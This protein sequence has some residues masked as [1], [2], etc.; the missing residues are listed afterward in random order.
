M[1]I[2][3]SQIQEVEKQLKYHEDSIQPLRKKLHELKTQ[4][5]IQNSA[6]PIYDSSKFREKKLDVKNAYETKIIW[7]D[8]GTVSEWTKKN[9][10]I[11]VCKYCKNPRHQKHI[12]TGHDHT[13]YSYDVCDCAG[14]KRSGGKHY[15]KLD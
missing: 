5:F 11:W 15:S 4:H 13:D 9:V 14:A 12:A 2:T 7:W 6:R 8:T 1:K 10:F 3:K